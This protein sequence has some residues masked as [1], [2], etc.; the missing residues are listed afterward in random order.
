MRYFRVLLIIATVLL[1]PYACL[2]RNVMARGVGGSCASFCCRGCCEVGEACPAARGIGP[3]NTGQSPTT[4]LRESQWC[5]CQGIV[6]DL[7]FRA[8]ELELSRELC[9]QFAPT[10]LS[11]CHSDN[12]IS[13]HDRWDIPPPQHGKTARVV[14]HSLLIYL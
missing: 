9:S 7:G 6:W 1:C 10:A 2:V 4:P 12:P 3:R 14:Y 8:M 5:L 13:K 11:R